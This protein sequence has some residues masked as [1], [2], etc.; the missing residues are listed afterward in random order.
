VLKIAT[1]GD[2]YLCIAGCPEKCDDH[3]EK[4]ANMALEMLESVKSIVAP[5]GTQVRVRIGMHTGPV[6][7]GVVGIKMI[8]YQVSPL[9]FYLL[10]C[11]SLINIQIWGD[12]VQIAQ[13][14]ESSGKASH[15]HVSEAAYLTI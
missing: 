5:D 7:A 10:I 4:I 9:L 8:H 14:M 2:A 3:A 6:I 11:V 1:I 15:L 13:K 12:S